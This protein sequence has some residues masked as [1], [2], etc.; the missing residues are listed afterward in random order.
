MLAAVLACASMT[1]TAPALAHESEQYTL[2][3]GRD[4]ADLGP[5]F[6]RILYDAVVGATAEANAAI[7][8]AVRDGGSPSQL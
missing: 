1:C 2:P 3:A 4:F 8:E 6:S 5:Y 7:E